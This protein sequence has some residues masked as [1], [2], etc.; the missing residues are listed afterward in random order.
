MFCVFKIIFYVCIRHEWVIPKILPQYIKIT[1]ATQQP[2]PSHLQS[3]ASMF[4][5]M[6]PY[7]AIHRGKTMV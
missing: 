4:R 6:A 2:L 3:F 1:S 5:T 7:I